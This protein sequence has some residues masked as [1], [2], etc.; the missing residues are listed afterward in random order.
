M[1]LSRMAPFISSLW[2]L[3]AT[4][5]FVMPQSRSNPNALYGS[6]AEHKLSVLASADE[7]SITDVGTTEEVR[8]VAR[9][10][11]TAF[12]GNIPFGTITHKHVGAQS[13]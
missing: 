6:V 3:V 2:L 13:P 12:V 10:R 7:T 8:S 9:E 1:M 5:A 11:Y 4:E